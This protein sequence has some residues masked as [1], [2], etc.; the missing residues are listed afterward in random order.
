MVGIQREPSTNLDGFNDSIFSFLFTNFSG[1]G[2]IIVIFFFQF[3]D[4][5]FSLFG[6]AW[7]C[8]FDSFVRLNM[9]WGSFWAY[10]FVLFQ[11][12]KEI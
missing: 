10:Y 1:A 2:Y 3:W 12:T 4:G 5:L 7:I 11:G 6:L 8:L 9:H